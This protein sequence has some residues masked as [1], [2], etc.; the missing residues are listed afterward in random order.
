MLINYFVVHFPHSPTVCKADSSR[1]AKLARFTSLF[2]LVVILM[3]P[4]MYLY[5]W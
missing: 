5:V 1:E 4:F 3:L 2:L